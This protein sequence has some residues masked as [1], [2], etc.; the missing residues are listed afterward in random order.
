LDRARC[1]SGEVLVLSVPCW[2][3]LGFARIAE[4]VSSVRNWSLYLEDAS[5]VPVLVDDSD[6]ESD[7]EE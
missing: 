5:A 7:P 4:K 3:Y 2:W 6:S 1:G